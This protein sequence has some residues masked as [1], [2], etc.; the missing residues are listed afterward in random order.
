MGALGKYL[1]F[2]VYLSDYDGASELA[3][4]FLPKILGE[5]RNFLDVL[6]GELIPS[7][8]LYEF[9]FV[10]VEV[11]D[12]LGVDIYSSD[13]LG[14]EPTSISQHLLDGDGDGQDPLITA[15]VQHDLIAEVVRL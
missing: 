10:F 8:F 12:H 3:L 1:I 6:F 9:L 4:Q 5:F 2:M 11:P 7:I 15:D 14:L 13:H